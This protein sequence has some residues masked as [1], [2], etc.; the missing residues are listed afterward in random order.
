M[1]VTVNG[2][3]FQITAA[4]GVLTLTQLIEQ[5]GAKPPFAVAINGDFVARENYAA[6]R[7]DGTEQVDI[8]TPVFGG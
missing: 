6:T 3:V 8:V 2:E 4:S 7:L 1:T 5:Y